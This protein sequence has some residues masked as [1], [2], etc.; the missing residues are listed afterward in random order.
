MKIHASFYAL[1]SFPQLI[2]DGALDLLGRS[3]FT[4]DN[5]KAM[6]HPGG[7]VNE[8]AQRGDQCDYE[9]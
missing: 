9:I 8:F 5:A 3:C 6:S 2:L 4:R 7:A 1:Q